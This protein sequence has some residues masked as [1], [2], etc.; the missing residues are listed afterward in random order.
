MQEVSSAR[1]LEWDT[2]TAANNSFI[3]YAEI[4]SQGPGG[5]AAGPRP[6]WVHPG[7]LPLTRAAGYTAQALLGWS[8]SGFVEED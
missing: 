7:R 8:S 5:A 6:A 2:N 4:N 3:F 1:W